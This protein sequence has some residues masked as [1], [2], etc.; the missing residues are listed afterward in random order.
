MES[1]YIKKALLFLGGDL[2]KLCSDA[3]TENDCEV[4]EGIL[5]SIEAVT[6]AADEGVLASFIRAQLV[7]LIERRGMPLCFVLVFPSRMGISKEKD[8]DGTLIAR[9]LFLAFITIGMDQKFSSS[10][11]HLLVIIKGEAHAKII[12]N[13]P[14][15]LLQALKL[16]NEKMKA[17]IDNLVS[18]KSTFAKSFLVKVVDSDLFTAQSK[19]MVKGFLSQINARFN[20][21]TKVSS[22]APPKIST[23][24]DAPVNLVFIDGSGVIYLDG[25][26]VED[27]PD[28]RGLEQN[29]FHVLGSL[30]TKN[31][32]DLLN[33]IKQGVSAGFNDVTFGIDDEIVITIGTRCTIDATAATG[34]AQLL[35]SE[36]ARYKKKKVIVSSVNDGIMRRS[37]GY[38]MIR[39]FIRVDVY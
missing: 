6:R 4:G 21:E 26:V 11:F 10:R 32:K 31:L 19:L 18:D 14:E 28:A 1:I 27:F 23:K 24:N 38:S 17:R 29:Q 30:T 37:H 34:L 12:E 8:P 13:H 33:R 39:E 2:R 22:I 20:L 9:A 3:F 36:L 16:S 15:K 25:A 35:V 5:D 7:S